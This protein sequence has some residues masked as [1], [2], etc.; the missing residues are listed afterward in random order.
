MSGEGVRAAVVRMALEAAVSGDEAVVERVYAD[1]V[2]GWSPVATVTSRAELAADMYGRKGA[3]SDVAL[4]LDAVDEVGDKLITEW[5]LAATHTG[6]LELDDDFRL[7]ATGRQVE[8][9]G[10]LIAEFDGDRIK[11]FRH[12]WD[13]VAL[14]QGLGLLPED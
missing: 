2:A 7:E 13:E 3:F 5:R 1:D 11:R 4:A 14:L 10:V 9:R 8:L 12:Y 6:A